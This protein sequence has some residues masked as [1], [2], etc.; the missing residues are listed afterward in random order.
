MDYRALNVVTVKDRF[1]IPTI[2]E[3]LDELGNASV[4]SKIDF[5]SSYH[6]IRVASEDTHKTSF[7]TFDGHYEFLVMPFG[8]TDAP[9]TFQS[10]MNDLLRPYLRQFVLVFFYDILMY[11]T[12]LDDHLLHLRLILDLLAT[13]HFVVKLCKCVFAEDTVTYLGYVIS[14]KG[15]AP[16]PEKVAAIMNWPQPRLLT[17]LR[18]FLGLIGFYRRFVQGYAMLAAPLTDLLRNSRFSWNEEAEKAFLQLKLQMTSMPVLHLPDFSKIFV[19]E[20]DA[21]GV[22]IGVVLSQGGHPRA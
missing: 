19:V 11:I 22:A 2:D 16:D 6:Q 5:H 9:S 1:P 7:R 15:V 13:N 21:S 10:A 14:K 8:L 20:T 4:F 17:A 18:G 3:L 12:N